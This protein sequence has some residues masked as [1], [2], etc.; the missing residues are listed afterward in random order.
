MI[1]QCL[2]SAWQETTHTD[3]GREQNILTL[4]QRPGQVPREGPW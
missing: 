1:P 3:T 2:Y 4:P